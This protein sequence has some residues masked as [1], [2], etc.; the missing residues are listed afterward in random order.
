MP[1]GKKKTNKGNG[2]GKELSMTEQTL[3]D[4]VNR[5][6]E[7]SVWAS[8]KESS[9]IRQSTT[10]HAFYKAFRKSEYLQREISEVKQNIR[11][12]VDR[13][14]MRLAMNAVDKAL[15]DKDLSHKDKHNYVKLVYDKSLGD[16]V[17]P[18]ATTTIKIGN[19]QALI[20]TQVQG[21]LGEDD[22]VIDVE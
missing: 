22:D 1:K 11:E 2:K 16:T 5:K 14:Q 4:V 10:P 6:P 3:L 18:H 21:K 17:I 20:Q 15:K 9:E 7:Q 12:Y 19:I 13:K 8:C